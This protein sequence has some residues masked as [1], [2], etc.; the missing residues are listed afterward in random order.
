LLLEKDFFILSYLTNTT[1]RII[2]FLNGMIFFIHRRVL[3]M[4]KNNKFLYPMVF[5]G[6]I[7]VFGLIC[8]L[9]IGYGQGKNSSTMI[10]M[11]NPASVYC[12]K[13]GGNLQIKKDKQGNE[14][15]LCI[16]PDGSTCDEWQFFNKKCKKG[17]SL[18]KSGKHVPAGGQ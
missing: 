10:A 1:Y 14:Y 13:K 4:R 2:T 6:I 12:V 17:D 18:K 9:S 3:F 16:F 15:G 7:A 5:V 11:A 8:C